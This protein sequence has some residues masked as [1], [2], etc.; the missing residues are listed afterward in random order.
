MK[1]NSNNLLQGLV[2]L[3]GIFVLFL[4]IRMPML[5]GRAKD[6][7][8]FQIYSD[9]FILYGY[10]AAIVF[11]VG[12]YKTF[13]LL[14]FIGQ[15]D[16]DSAVSASKS[17]KYCAVALGIFIGAAAVY[18]SQTHHK[19]DDPAGFIGM[20]MVLILINIGVYFLATKFEKRFL[21]KLH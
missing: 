12:L 14:G 19:D 9:P 13:K 3:L 16:F 7:N 5:E 6:L 21:Q 17:I 10:A 18:I 2:A 8:L 1:K 11:F 20:C 4:L 15:N